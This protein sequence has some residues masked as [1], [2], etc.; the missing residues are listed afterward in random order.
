MSELLFHLVAAADWPDHAP[1]YDP[2]SLAEEGF[3]HLSSADQVPV[4]SLRFY[5]DTPGL[6]LVA[7]HPEHLAAPL[8]WEDL[9][10]HGEFPHLYGRIDSD[11]VVSVTP[12]TAGEPVER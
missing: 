4:T 12:Y 6:M 7:L 10:G 1:D 9:L 2:P 5:A 3:I 8:V 11:A